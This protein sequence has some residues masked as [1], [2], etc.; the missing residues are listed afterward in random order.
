MRTK[1][2]P[3]PSVNSLTDS[4]PV[5]LEIVLL[6]LGGLLMFGALISG[7]VAAVVPVARGGLRPGRLRA[8]RRRPRGARLRRP[9]RSFVHDLAVVALIVILFR[10]G[11]EV[12]AEMLQRE[13]HL[14]FRKLAL[15]MPIT[16][17]IVACAAHWIVGLGWLESC[18]LGALLSPTDPVLSSS[19][20]TNP[21]VPRLVRHSL[22]LES[23]LNDGLA[24]PGGARV[25][26]GARRRRGL[27]V[28][29]VRAPGRDARL[30]V[31]HRRSAWVAAK[32]M[33]RGRKLTDSIPAHAQ[34]L[35][36]L[37]VA[38]AIYGDRGRAAA[39]GQRLHRRVRRRDHARDPAPRPARQLREPRRRHRRDRQARDLR[40]VRRRC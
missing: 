39:R 25:H 35:Y 31:R 15:A 27:R 22:N 38:F 36:A 10:D 24:L 26:R 13:W 40:R 14:P 34:S 23:G 3:S 19:V 37:G 8:R 4:S 17:A 11:L 18:L 7:L 30:R 1:L 21:R 28:V 33:P 32:L 29:A 2:R 20:V 5:S 12:E 6:V 16:G 9:A